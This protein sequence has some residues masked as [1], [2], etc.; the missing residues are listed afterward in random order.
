MFKNLTITLL[1]GLLAGTVAAGKP[2]LKP[3]WPQS[4][5]PFGNFNPRQYGCKLVDDLKQVPR[6]SGHCNTCRVKVVTR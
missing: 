3:A 2:D 5:G 1:A 6:A 4:S